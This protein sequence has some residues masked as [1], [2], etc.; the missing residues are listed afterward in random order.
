MSSRD[1]S[2]LEIDVAE[3]ATWE[4]LHEK[5]ADAFQFPRYY[6]RNWNAFDECIRDVT[7][8]AKVTIRG[9]EKLRAKLPFEAELLSQCIRDFVAE[10]AGRNVIILES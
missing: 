5:L 9:L 3:V 4:A 1:A 6:G 8:P 10:D 2:S 7:L